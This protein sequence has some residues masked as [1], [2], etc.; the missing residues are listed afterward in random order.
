MIVGLDGILEEVRENVLVS[1]LYYI[2]ILVDKY[3]VF[4]VVVTVNFLII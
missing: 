4:V 3:T 1:I 2:S